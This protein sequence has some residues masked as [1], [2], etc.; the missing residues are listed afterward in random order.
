MLTL[1]LLPPPQPQ[2][3]LTLTLMHCIFLRPILEMVPFTHI[4][5]MDSNS[6]LGEIKK[7]LLDRALLQ[8]H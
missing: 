4:T 8:L 3:P 1:L 5:S 6:F 7:Q 2:I